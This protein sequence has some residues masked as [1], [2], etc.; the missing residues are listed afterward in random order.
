MD[1]RTNSPY[2]LLR[3]GLP[4]SYPS[5]SRDIRSDVAIIGGGIAGAFVCW[6]L[7]KKG[8]NVVVLDKRHIGNGSTAASTSLLQYEIDTP[9]TTLRQLVGEQNAVR[10]YLMGVEAIEEIADIC[11]S[12]N[13]ATGFR[14]KKSFQYASFKKDVIGL[15]QEFDLR[16]KIGI[17][18]SW[19]DEVGVKEKYGF[20]APA[21]LLSEAGAELDAYSLTH[22]IFH[23]CAGPGCRVFD[24][25]KVTGIRYNKQDVELMTN[26]GHKIKAKHLVIACGYESQIYLPQKVE[27]LQST[28][29]I[30]SEPLPKNVIWYGNSLIWE[31]SRPYLYLRTT[32]DHRA[33]IGGK[34]DPFWNPRKRELALPGKARALEKSFNKLFP[35]VPFKTDFQWAGTFA[36]TKDGLPF[37]GKIRQRPNTY[38]ALGFGGNGITFSVLA[39]KMISDALC[40][41][42]SRDAKISS[43]DR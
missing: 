27:K 38:F 11:K 43:F 35:D 31:T 19:L 37:V 8:F 3:N 33:L 17:K 15:Q 30:I 32:N 13:G 34:D 10:S 14:R 22:S 16:R 42:S 29:V 5:V 36:T 2:W 20:Y 1:L 7:H 21:G 39:G 40:G 12:V 41:K 4:F 28:Y 18:L 26:D 25:T 9:L 23:R 24:N 6:Y